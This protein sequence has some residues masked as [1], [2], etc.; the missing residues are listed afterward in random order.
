MKLSDFKVGQ[1]VIVAGGYKD[2]KPTEATVKKV[3]RKYVTIDDGWQTTFELCPNQEY[4]IESS[5][6][7]LGRQLFPSLEAYSRYSEHKALVY[8][9]AQIG[10]GGASVK[11]C[12]L[13]QLRNA[14]QILTGN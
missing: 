11:N 4:C 8:W 6:T 3:G 2:P 10:H 13:E 5:D 9:F 7:G 12:S 14:K 1:T